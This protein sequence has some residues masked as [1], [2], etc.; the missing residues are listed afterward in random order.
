MEMPDYK[1]NS[2]KY[3]KEQEE[4]REER[5]VSKVVQGNV[6][7]KKKTD[8]RKF[9]E[10][11]ISEE[12]ENIGSYIVMDVLFPAIKNTILDII[13]GSAEMLFGTGGSRRRSGRS[14]VDRVSYVNYNDRYRD[15]DRRPSENVRH[16]ACDFDDIV[17]DSRGE[18]EE[19]L[20]Q[21]DAMIDTYKVARVSDLYDL[22]GITGP[23]TA[24]RY[25]W[26]NLRNAE[27]V[28]L[29]DGGYLI[30]LPRAV[31]IDN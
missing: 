18:A 5:R 17:V 21:L 15:R 30:K 28:R 1:P 22:V 29:R 31:P 11:F 7:V 12:A 2:N 27:A 6:K 16:N 9:A 25:G 20:A 10:G 8:I 23:H 3:K 26:T 13:T 24:N 19:V 4:L 14:T